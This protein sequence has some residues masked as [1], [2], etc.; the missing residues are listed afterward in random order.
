MGATTPATSDAVSRQARELG[1]RIRSRRKAL[2]VTMVAAAEAAGM[3]R[4]TWHRIEKGNPSVTM[5]AWLAAASV[6]ALDLAAQERGQRADSLPDSGGWIPS[7]ICL[8]DYPQLRQ[9]A[10]QL[11]DTT[12]LAP[13]EAFNLYERNWRHL[14]PDALQP[15]EQAL[16]TALQQAFGEGRDV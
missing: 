1:D 4:V 11:E 3:S 8:S 9:L 13:Q 7:R 5:G 6:L 14:D 15:H 12:L 10:W 16:I 2:G